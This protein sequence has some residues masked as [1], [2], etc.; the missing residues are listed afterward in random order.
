MVEVLV[1]AKIYVNVSEVYHGISKLYH[2][3]Q[4]FI[5]NDILSNIR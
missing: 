1:K 3:Y 4:V 5:V 2:A